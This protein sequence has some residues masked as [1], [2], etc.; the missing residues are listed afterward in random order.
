MTTARIMTSS[1]RPRNGDLVSCFLKTHPNPV[2]ACGGILDP[3]ASRVVRGAA[4]H[5]L[6]TPTTWRQ[7]APYR[8]GCTII[9]REVLPNI[10]LIIVQMTR[11]G[12]II[13]LSI[14]GLS[15]SDWESWRFDS[16][17]MPGSPC[18]PSALLCLFRLKIMTTILSSFWVT[19]LDALIQRLL[20]SR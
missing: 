17:A 20:G 14:A 5:S 13:I 2:I 12:G 19:D 6:V 15:S 11:L 18:L 16:G 1:L 7:R 10:M 3:I 9:F 8:Q 4:H